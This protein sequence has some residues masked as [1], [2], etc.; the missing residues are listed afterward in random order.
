MKKLIAITAVL[1]TF[2]GAAFAQ[3]PM[4]GLGFRSGQALN[5]GS[6][7]LE[8]TPTVGIRHWFSPKMGVDGAIGFSTLSLENNG[9]TT[10][11][12]SGF[13]FDLGL[14]I[15]LRSWDK[16]NFILR[17][18]FAWTSATAKDKTIPT[19][20]NELTANVYAYSAEL[21]VEWMLAERLSV[22]AAQG[23]SFVNGKI[24]DNDSP[25][26]EAKFSGF[27]TTGS[28]FTQIGFH[29]YLW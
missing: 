23:I 10:D 22:S 18:G 9:T 29:V 21:E 13:S 11:E 28:S 14:P 6:V 3:A 7:G 5:T 24:E 17:P 19:P 1:M 15:S 12:G 27:N 4:G 26:S 16:V 20:P 8:A 2:A 25:A